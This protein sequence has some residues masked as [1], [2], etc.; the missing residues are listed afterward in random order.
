MVV[1]TAGVDRALGAIGTTFRLTRLYP[2]THPAVVE[3]LRQIGEALPPLAAVGTVEWKVGATGLHWHGQ[4]LLPRNSQIAELA[5]LLYARGIRAV[6]LNPG[7]TSE[8][9]LSL[10]AV[11]TGTI[12]P[13]DATLGRITLA[14]GRRTS[15]RLERLRAPAHGFPAVPEP[16]PAAP[17]SSPPAAP[18]LPTQAS[19]PPSPDQVM[20]KRSGVVFRPD[21]LPADVEAKRAIA[22]LKTAAAPEEQRAAVE[23]LLALAPQL[24]ALRDAVTVADAIAAL[25]RLLLAARDGALLEAIDQAAVALTDKSLVERMVQRLGEPRVPA[26]EREAL[27][28]AVGALAALSVPL[29]LDAFL[30]API[31]RRAPYRAAIRKA[32][33]RALE[34]LQG[35]LAD[36]EPQITAAAAELIGLTGSPQAAP[37]LLPLLRHRSELVREAALVGLAEAGGREISRPAMP[38]LKDESV[39]V[40][41]AATRAVAA[42]ADPASTTV[43][44]R[45]LDQEPDEGVQAELLRAI[46]RLG[47]KEALDVLAKYAESG[48]V[49]HRSNP[50]LRAAAIEGLRHVARPEARGL[51]ELYSK[52]KDPVVRKAAEAALK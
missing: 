36:R 17:D 39:S 45:R 1:D 47:A 28:A 26:E 42:G 21:V 44:I 3:A 38:A 30:A 6:T 20:G 19:G 49:M 14:L 2:P 7:M 15:Q 5:G 24:I 18:P 32:A 51:I 13:D 8:H 41:L 22:S 52:D 34:P 29:V 10:F 25:D 40:R 35:K 37:L 9:V 4:H 27:V 23:K 11:A 31:E 43:L 48:G 12:P 16:L 50:S 33:D 46:G